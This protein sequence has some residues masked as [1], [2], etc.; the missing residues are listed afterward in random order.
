MAGPAV[1]RIRQIPN[2]GPNAANCATSNGPLGRRRADSLQTS[3]IAKECKHGNPLSLL[4][5]LPLQREASALANHQRLHSPTAV[6]RAA[7]AASPVQSGPSP[8]P[9]TAHQI[10]PPPIKYC[11]HFLEIFEVFTTPGPAMGWPCNHALSARFFAASREEVNHGGTETRRR[12]R[13]F[14][15]IAGNT[16]SH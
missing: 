16:V 2:I 15:L 5:G 7:K 8:E 1:G 6:R 14:V 11:G 13:R 3:Q 9:E 12:A 10:L 4:L